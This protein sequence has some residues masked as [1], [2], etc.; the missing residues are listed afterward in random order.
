MAFDVIV[1]G[2]GPAGIGAAVAAARNGARVL[3]LEKSNC[4]GGMGTNGLVSMIRCAGDAGGIVREYWD[5]LAALDSA[6]ITDRHAVINPCVARVVALE[7]AIEAGA[8]VLF[9]TQAVGVEMAASQVVGVSIANKGGVQNVQASTTVDATGDGD[10]AA[11]AGA[12]FDKGRDPDGFLQAVSLNFVV[13]GVEPEK[14]PSWDEFRRLSQA[15]IA[16]GEVELPAF[17]E[18]LHYGHQWPGYPP[19]QYL[20]QFDLAME[21]DP[22]DP[23]SLSHGESLCQQRVLKI[24]RF[25]KQRV[26]GYENSA[27][28]NMAT[29]LGV[30][31]SRRIR[32]ERTLVEDDVLQARKHA[33]GI[34]RGEWYMDT[35]DGVK[36]TPEF[37]RR[38][39]PPPGEFY[40][41]PYGCLTPLE[42]DGLLVAGRCVSS[43]RMANGALRLQPTCMNLGQAAGTAAALC[44]KQQLAPRQLAAA[45][46]RA[47]LQSQGMEL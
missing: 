18:C 13:G 8:E 34:A 9:H 46:L 10:L 25:L 19:G 20:F 5:R 17:V 45:D 41:I 11:Q 38:L 44:A 7:M 24:W 12:P 4:L 16:S 2:G 31:E 15:A 30:R 21:I 28:V 47:L 43:T 22:S 37:K 29:H 35:H 14:R 23:A 26:S 1:A 39:A 42:I 27:L 6:V 3:L 32:G 33:D 40:D 36:K